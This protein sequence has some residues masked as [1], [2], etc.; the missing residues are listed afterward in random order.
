MNQILRTVML[1]AFFVSGFAV[2]SLAQEQDP[3]KI[4]GATICGDCH[5]AAHATWKEMKHQTNFLEFHKLADTKAVLKKLGLR[6]AK[7]GICITCHYT[8]QQEEGK[9]RAKAISGVSCESCH[10]ASAEWF[11]VH[12]NYGKTASGEKATKETESA[13]HKKMR[14]ESTAAA[15]MIRPDQPYLLTQNCFQCHTVPNEE[16]VNKGGHTPGSD[17]ELVAWSSGEVRHNFQQTE[18]KENRLAA[19]DYDPAN[20]KRLLY[21]MGQILDL[22][23]ALRGLAEATTEGTY[24]DA[25]KNRAMA[26]ADKLKAI[27]GKA[28]NT[29]IQA[30][31]DA[32]GGA[33][34]APN[35]KDGLVAVADQIR[36]NAQAFGASNDG[37]SLAAIGAMIPGADQYKGAV[38]TP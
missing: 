32:A 1:V 15:G 13:E 11:D 10:G 37:S 36:T 14:L 29:N 6:S 9:R 33:S 27:Q 18:E 38:Y 8:A 30:I 2:N 16:L 31:L 17:F 20:R 7:R 12:S 19:R 24:A 34:L 5:K 35:N 22:E 26:A 3:K 25:M 23:Y 4:K 21:V 28:S